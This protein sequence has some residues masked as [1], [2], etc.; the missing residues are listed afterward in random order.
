MTRNLMTLGVV[1]TCLV[2]MAC[3]LG[4]APT[5]TALPTPTVAIAVPAPTQVVAPPSVSDVGNALRIMLNSDDPETTLDTLTGS[6]GPLVVH[7]A[8]TL[9][10]NAQSNL[11]GIQSAILQSTE[12]GAD[13][14]PGVAALIGYD[15]PQVIAPLIEYAMRDVFVITGDP[16]NPEVRPFNSLWESYLQWKRESGFGVEE[17]ALPGPAEQYAAFF[18]AKH[19]A[20]F[21]APGTGTTIGWLISKDPDLR[22]L[23]QR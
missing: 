5:S 2:V 13:P 11:P 12:G 23:N 17:I 4:K 3:T 19:A 21:V 18:I 9:L 22:R 14:I 7:Q 1:V 15:D 10:A 16:S 8:V 20:A 6:H